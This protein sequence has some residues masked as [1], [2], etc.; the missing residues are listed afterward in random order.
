MPKFRVTYTDSVLREAV[1][2]ASSK[3]EAEAIVRSQM[4]NAEHHHTSD[5]WTDDWEVQP[6]RRPPLVNRHCFECGEQ[7][8]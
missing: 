6:Y 3:Q 4:E 7:R 2:N 1:V 5:G 8:E